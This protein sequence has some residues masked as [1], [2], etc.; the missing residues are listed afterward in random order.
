MGNETHL[1]DLLLEPSDSRL[2]AV[3]SDQSS[4]GVVR[5]GDVG[6]LESSTILG[7][8]GEVLGRDGSLLLGDVS[9]DLEDL[10]S[11][12]EGGGDGV[13]SVGG[14]DEEDAREI[15]GNIELRRAR[16]SI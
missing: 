9:R 11:V 7:L 13:E 14:A 6:V 5:E 2:S 10:H 1:L 15:D 3:V 12:E 16:V 4:D 8:R